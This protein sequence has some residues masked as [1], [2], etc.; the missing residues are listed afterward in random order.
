M[1]KSSLHVGIEIFYTNLSDRE[2]NL[3]TYDM[4]IAAM[5]V[6]CSPKFPNIQY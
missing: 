4:K 1:E 6:I 3:F 2:N 5:L